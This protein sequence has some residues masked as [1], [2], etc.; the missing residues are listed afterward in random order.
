M[1]FI[2]EKR[3]DNNKSRIHVIFFLINKLFTARNND[4]NFTSTSFH[5]KEQVAD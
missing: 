5:N 3:S 2:L 1:Y 4:Y